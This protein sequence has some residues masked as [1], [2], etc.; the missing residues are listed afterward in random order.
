MTDRK[1][2]TPGESGTESSPGVARRTADAVR[3]GLTGQAAVALRT[4]SGVLVRRG[5]KVLPGDTVWE[6]LGIVG[7][8]GYAAGYT[9]VH[10]GSA[11]PFVV[12]AAALA[13]CVAAWVVAPAADEVEPASEDAEEQL[14]EVPPASAQEAFALWLLDTLGDRSG[15]HLADLYPAMR[16]LPGMEGRTDPELRAA[17]RVLEVPVERTLRV[18]PVAG[19][20]GVSRAAVEALLTPRS[21]DTDN[22]LESP[23][24]SG[25]DL[26][27]SPDGERSSTAVESA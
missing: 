15:I 14:L 11:A 21:P 1:I 6:R 10:A 16:H 8:G 26:R 22:T 3:S 12:P 9:A 18:G 7:A 27:K 23:V 5:W 4:G 17:L 2:T 25:T 19:R 13:W 24:E 20:S